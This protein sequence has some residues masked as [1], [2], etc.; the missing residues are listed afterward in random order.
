[1]AFQI[2]DLPALAQR[3]ANAFRGNLKGSDAR[4]WPNNV[5]VSAKVMAGAVYEN[6]SFLQWISKQILVST[7]DGEFVERHARE[8]GMARLPATFATGAVVIAGDP[9]IA[10]PAGIVL[11]R[12]DN[13]AY[14]VIS[15]GVTDGDGNATVQVRAQ[16]P[17]RAGNAASGVALT[18]TAALDRLNSAA[19]VASAGIG[20]GADLE[21]IESLRSRVLFRKRLPPHG[22]A[23]HDY[24]AWA[25]EI[26]GVTR[27]FVDPVT[28]SND[29][30]SVGVWFL[31][32]DTYSDGIPQG[33]DV[34]NVADYIETVRPA[35]ALV[36]VQAP[37]K[38][39]VNITITGL[40]PDTTIVRD[41][42]RAELADLFRR[43]VA[44]STLTNPFTLY[45]SKVVEAISIA[46][47]EDH[48]TLT[49][50]AGDTAATVGKLLTL[51][52]VTFA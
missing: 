1:M 12:A 46:V 42:V 9:G 17:G 47:G 13:M 28:Q 4:L 38:Q 10:V 43:R 37:I 14:D 20:S 32:D 5:A 45:R 6:F 15:A 40:S 18:M 25:R 52:S 51:G 31:M 27:V 30:T 16:S 11:L 39:A 29:R 33:S 3:A 34:Q 22:G 36:D 44:V 50:P 19:V 26:N 8:Y 41:A 48:H 24:V 2:P 23:A 49:A 35:G 21:S 7:A